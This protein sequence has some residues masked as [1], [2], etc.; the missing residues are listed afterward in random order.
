MFLT[1][2][3]KN[4][5]IREIITNVKFVEIGLTIK[6]AI[7]TADKGVF[8]KLALIVLKKILC[9]LDV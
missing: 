6:K 5:K 8:L 2:T 4:P 9:L 7:T 1:S 3:R